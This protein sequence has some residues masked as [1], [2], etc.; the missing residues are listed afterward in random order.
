M[1]EES[2][3]GV[4]VIVAGAGLAGLSAARELEA[5]GASTIVVEDRRL[6]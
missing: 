5:R 1:L 2:L 4:T 3:R 6:G